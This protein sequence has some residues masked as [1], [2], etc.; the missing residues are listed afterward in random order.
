MIFLLVCGSNTLSSRYWVNSYQLIGQDKKQGNWIYQAHSINRGKH[1]HKNERL[2]KS[3]KMLSHRFDQT[4]WFKKMPEQ[5]KIGNF[6]FMKIS[7]TQLIY[8]N[9]KTFLCECICVHIQWLFDDFLLGLNLKIQ[10]KWTQT[11]QRE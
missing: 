10:H 1:K 6:I 2:K 9:G 3:K 4:L 7:R 5:N 8:R 11:E